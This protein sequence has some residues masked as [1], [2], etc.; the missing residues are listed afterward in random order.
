MSDNHAAAS[1]TFWD[2]KRVVHELPHFQFVDVFQGKLLCNRDSFR[3]A[4]EC[5]RCHRIRKIL[6]FSLSCCEQ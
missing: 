5:Q 3:V 2:H 6:T 1:G 4:L